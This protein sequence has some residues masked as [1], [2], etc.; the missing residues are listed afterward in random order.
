[1]R[2]RARPR[3]RGTRPRLIGGAAVLLSLA[4]LTLRSS[5]TQA[6]LVDPRRPTTIVVG[7]SPGIA[8]M[9]RIDGGRR[10][11]AH[12]AL[13]QH[14][15]LVWRAPSRGGLDL[16]PIAVDARGAILT[17]SAGHPELVRH[18]ADG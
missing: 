16:S 12:D 1:M 2:S 5:L 14:P 15:K 3:D 13:P 6:T 7:P 8:P 10:G 18:S 17:A 9:F 11:R 4:A